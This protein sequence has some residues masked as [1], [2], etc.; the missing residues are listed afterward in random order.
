MGLKDKHQSFYKNQTYFQS[1]RHAFHGFRDLWVEERN[2]SFHIKMGL[3][4]ILLGLL[5][6]INLNDW[7]WLLLCILAVISSEI[8]NTLFERTSDLIVGNHYND[9]VKKIKDVAAANVVIAA[10]FAVVV[11]CII[12]IPI[13]IKLILNW[14]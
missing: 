12:F 9:L 7:L 2:F 14:R 11:G 13:I 1:F 8:I 6:K 10:I 5:L 3:L 4:V